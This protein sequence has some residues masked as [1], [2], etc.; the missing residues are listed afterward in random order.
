MHLHELYSM[1][2]YRLFVTLVF[3][4]LNCKDSCWWGWLLWRSFPNSLPQNE[5]TWINRTRLSKL[6][7]V[8]Q[9][10]RQYIVNNIK[11]DCR[12]ALYLGQK[13]TMESLRTIKSY[14]QHTIRRQQY[15][16]IRIRVIS[17]IY[18]IL[19][20]FI[21]VLLLLYIRKIWDFAVGFKGVGTIPVYYVY[22]F[23][24][25]SK[26]VSSEESMRTCA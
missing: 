1:I 4:V 20:H 9:Q 2:M 21:I 22:E 5:Y 24:N 13:E 14:T 12:K 25:L 16:V 26:T 18:Y 15:A 19:Y 11:Y 8:L 23:L 10:L 17:I 7:F 6:N 3:V